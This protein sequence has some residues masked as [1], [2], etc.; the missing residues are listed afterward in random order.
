MLHILLMLLHS[1]DRKGSVQEV[2][3][4]SFSQCLVTCR[5][6][7]AGRV[8]AGKRC[9]GDAHSGCAG[10]SCRSGCWAEQMQASSWV[11]L[12]CT[13]AAADLTR[14]TCMEICWRAGLPLATSHS[15]RPSLANRS[16]RY[17]TSF[18]IIINPQLYLCSMQVC[19]HVDMP[20]L[21]CEGQV[22]CHRQSWKKS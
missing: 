19:I 6:D 16:N 14:T 15:S 13:L 20:L 21:L 12:S 17:T 8:T 3:A 2:C 5:Q 4:H 9:Q 1:F 22:Y 18:I 11:R 7:L 10:R